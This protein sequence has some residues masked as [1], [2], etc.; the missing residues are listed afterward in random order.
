MTAMCVIA[1]SIPMRTEAVGYS[2]VAFFQKYRNALFLSIFWS[3]YLLQS[4]LMRPQFQFSL[5]MLF[6]HIRNTQ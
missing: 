2:S 1:P 5:F 3:K 6:Q 4:V